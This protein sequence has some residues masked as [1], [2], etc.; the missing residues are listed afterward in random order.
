M[1]G[2]TTMS[3]TAQH[4]QSEAA[5]RRLFARAAVGDSQARDELIERFLPLARSVAK[6]YERTNESSE[7]LFQV[8]CVGLVN[9]VDRFDPQRGARFSSYA[10]PTIAGELKRHFRDH[11]WVVHVPRSL[12]EL[13]LTVDR[14]ATNLEN[15]HGRAPTITELADAAGVSVEEVLEAREVGRSRRLASL[16]APV[17][18]M[19]GAGTV[20]DTLA[21]IRAQREHEQAEQRVVLGPLIATLPERHRHVLSLRFESDLTQQQIAD[22]FGVSQMQISRMLAQALER[23]GELARAPRAAW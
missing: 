22:R 7:D 1:Q 9:A 6:R 11:T 16:D 19:D 23:L 5:E 17:A 3:A 10:V 15:R 4:R 18:A 14:A 21:S 20:A 13:S 8:A 2:A 12:S